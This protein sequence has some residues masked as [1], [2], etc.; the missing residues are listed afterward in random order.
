MAPVFEV[1]F[2]HTE[3][4]WLTRQKKTLRGK[5]SSLLDGNSKA[6]EDFVSCG[7][8]VSV[9]Q[10]LPGISEPIKIA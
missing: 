3:M 2:K 7:E 10:V 1:L 6:Q 5:S 8:E 9:D 4:N